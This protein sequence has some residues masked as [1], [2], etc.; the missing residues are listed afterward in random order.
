VPQW[1]GA[2]RAPSSTA[3]AAICAREVKPSL[4]RMCSTWVSA[5]RCEMTSFDAICLLL[6]PRATSPAIWRSRA[7]SL[8]EADLLEAP[9]TGDSLCSRAS[10]TSWSVSIPFPDR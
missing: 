9:A 4:T 6:K 8:M 3:H 2:G 7:V 5:V 10:A 1:A